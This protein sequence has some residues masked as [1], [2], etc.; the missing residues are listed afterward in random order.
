MTLM[1]LELEIISR[2]DDPVFGEE[3][4]SAWVLCSYMS[5]QDTK[6]QAWLSSSRAIPLRSP[7]E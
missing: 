3:D 5:C 7:R 6:K 4:S 1:K 2:N